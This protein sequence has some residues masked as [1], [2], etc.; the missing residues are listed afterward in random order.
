MQ[1]SRLNCSRTN[2]NQDEQL[3]KLFREFLS[4]LEKEQLLKFLSVC[5]DSAPFFIDP[6]HMTY[7]EIYF[8]YQRGDLCTRK[9]PFSFI[10]AA[11][12]G[13]GEKNV[14]MF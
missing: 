2:A 9:F 7:W 1:I 12:D 4:T 14:S 3:K 6:H 10:N 11:I 13:E 5:Q 8:L